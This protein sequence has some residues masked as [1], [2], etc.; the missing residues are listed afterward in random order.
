[1]YSFIF[2]PEDGDFLKKLSFILIL[3]LTLSA[4]ENNSI[5]YD[6]VTDEKI[7]KGVWIYY[8]ELSDIFNND[9]KIFE[10]N[11]NEV[12]D[13]C[14]RYGL[15]TVFVQ[16]RPFGDS[17]YPSE[18]FPWSKYLTGEQ[19]KGVDFDPLKIMIE[20]AHKKGLTFHGWINP[21]RVSFSDDID[22]L[23]D[24]NPAKKLADTSAVCKISEGIYYNPAAISSQKLILSGVKEIVNNYE[25]DG[26]HID[27]YFYPSESEEID[28]AEYEAY[29]KNGG[30][31]NLND[32]RKENINTFVAGLY[33]LVKSID[34]DVLVSISPAGNI[35]NNYSSLFA[36][37]KKWASEPG[38]CD[39]IIPQLYFGYN[40]QTLAYD[41]ALSQWL[42]ITNTDNIKLITGIAAYKALTP[43]TDEWKDVNII[44]SQISE[45]FKYENISGYC[46]FSYSSLVGLEEKMKIIND[47]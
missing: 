22:S 2:P 19:G 6:D 38:F 3:L 20:T 4:C 11:I 29:T 21:F 10:K 44:S 35:K 15:N 5:E 25:V 7:I 31:L 1:M 34:N 28:F 43:E 39:M 24:S 23:C 14:L 45:S 16:I 30:E 32:W 18:I 41:E 46:L 17:F 36:D 27:D 33:S 42:E 40:N 9:K 26:I 12:F 37:V 13:N 47:K 8:N